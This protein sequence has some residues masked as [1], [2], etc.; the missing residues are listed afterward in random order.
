[1]NAT[2]EKI[3]EYQHRVE[4]MEAQLS[5]EN[6]EMSS[7]NGRQWFPLKTISWWWEAYDYRIKP[8]QSE[9]WVVH[10]HKNQTC[11][12]HAYD[13]PQEA[14]KAAKYDPS[15]RVVHAREVIEPR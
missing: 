8:K 10:F 9:W 13:T 3:A 15:C 1:M 6:I 14:A 4:I 5:G 11:M 7:D 2:D 12:S